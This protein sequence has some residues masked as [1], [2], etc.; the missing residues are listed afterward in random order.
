MKTNY[1]I[2][3][4]AASAMSLAGCNLEEKDDTTANNDNDDSTQDDFKSV[5]V[6]ATSSTQW[7]YLDLSA[8]TEVTAGEDWD[9]AFK[10][11][12]VRSNPARV[13][14]ALAEPQEDFFDT[15]GDPNVNV[16]TNATAGSELEHLLAT[17]NVD[18]LTFTT[19]SVD[20]AIGRDGTNFYSTTM[21][22]FSISAN[23]D[24]WWLLKSAE[25]DSYAKVNFTTVD[26]NSTTHVVTLA[27]DFYVRGSGDNSFSSTPVTWNRDEA[28]ENCFDFNSA[29]TVDCGSDD[30]DVQYTS[31]DHSMMILVNGGYSGDGAGGLY[32][33]DDQGDNDASNDLHAMTQAEIDAVDASALTDDDF[34]AD[35]GA[36]AN[37]FYSPRGVYSNSYNDW[38]AYA[39]L[40]GHGIWP[41]YRVYALKETDTEVVT[42]FQIVDYYNEADEG[43]HITV[44]Y[45]ILD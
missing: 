28:S 23:D 35:A 10:T 16:W 45:R 44:R 43:R 5:Q 40:G 22:P 26:Y 41:N 25:G 33:A 36:S 6:D 9:L 3:L 19:D 15:T 17:Y 42:L 13:E 34:T 29:S 32:I 30:W 8:G 12:D 39:L 18:D 38:Y 2:V 4:M 11:T 7:A 27:V 31:I 21:N 37:M 20:A 24:A 14:L 1:W